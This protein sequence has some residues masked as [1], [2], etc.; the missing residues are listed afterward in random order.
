MQLKSPWLKTGN[1]IRNSYVERTAG[2]TVEKDMDAKKT[3]WIV[4]KSSIPK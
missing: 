1:V 3:Y 2:K 4:P